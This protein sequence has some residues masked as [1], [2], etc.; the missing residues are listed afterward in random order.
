MLE[1]GYGTVYF[2]QDLNFTGNRT[3]T[4]VPSEQRWDLDTLHVKIENL[5][6]GGY[7]TIGYGPNANSP[8]IHTFRSI[9]DTDVRI[10]NAGV[11]NPNQ[12]P[13][14]AV[15]VGTNLLGSI[16]AGAHIVKSGENFIE[17]NA[18]PQFG[19]REYHGMEV[20]GSTL[21]LFGGYNGSNYLNDVWS[22]NADGINWTS[23]AASGQFSPRSQFGTSSFTSG[24]SAGFVVIG[25]TNG[26]SYYS[27][28]WF[29]A[30]GT[31]WTQLSTGAFPGRSGAGVA[32]LNGL[33][34]V[35]GG[36]NGTSVLNDVWSSPDGVTWTEVTASA[37]FTARQLFGMK[38]FMGKLFVWGGENGSSTAL[39]DVWSSPDG[40]TWI[41]SYVFNAQ[42]VRY[43][44][45]SDVGFYGLGKQPA[46][47][48][49]GGYDGTNYNNDIWESKDGCC[50]L[51]TVPNNG[52]S[53]RAGH[54]SKKMGNSIYLTGGYNGSSYLNDVWRTTVP[55]V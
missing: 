40:V 7:L 51:Q 54:A 6:E 34:Y 12:Q 46:I 21:Y 27:D 9:C 3:V 20:L 47:R 2:N 49:F 22:L 23:V 37:G 30:N 28:V 4:I 18:N 33:L 50:W 42:P 5:D 53:I 41:Q 32:Y 48:I 35:A 52:F 14:N 1:N 15:W 10:R 29:T 13:L 39:Q 25:G 55:I 16:Q 17:L 45:S 44:F 11:D 24:A 19:V 36:Y 43:A 38:P 8:E 31:T 26:I